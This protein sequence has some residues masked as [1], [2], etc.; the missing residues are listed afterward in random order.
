MKLVLSKSNWVDGWY[1]IERAEHDGRKW[2]EQT[3][4]NVMRFMDSARISDA[5]V[6]GT[7]GEMLEIAE[8][9]KSR[10]SYESRRCAVRV[11]GDTAYFWS[12]RNS[13]T[14][15]AIPISDA[16]NFAEQVFAMFRASEVA[17]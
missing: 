12:P 4:P 9:I 11:E 14:E 1:L 15:A 10:G 8:A 2:F 13:T 6:E 17:Q 3:E 16:D 5:C 7:A